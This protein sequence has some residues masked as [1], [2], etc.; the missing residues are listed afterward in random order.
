MAKRKKQEFKINVIYP[1][2]GPTLDELLRSPEMIAIFEGILITRKLLKPEYR[3]K[4]DSSQLAS[5]V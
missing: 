1:E 2:N 3:Q 4:K 5:M